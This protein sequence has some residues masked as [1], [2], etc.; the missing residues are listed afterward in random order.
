MVDKMVVEVDER[1]LLMLEGY[2]NK[3]GYTVRRMD[4]LL[5]HDTN[6]VSG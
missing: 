3:A 2:P 5:V 1:I 6:S 4:E